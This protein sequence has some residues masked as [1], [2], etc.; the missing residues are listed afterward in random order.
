MQ[1]PAH[2]QLATDL[3]K[4]NKG[5]SR[6]WQ[7]LSC[8]GLCAGMSEQAQSLALV[9]LEE[10]LLW[11]PLDS[12]GDGLGTSLAAARLD[13]RTYLSFSLIFLRTEGKR[14]ERWHQPLTCLELLNM[15][16][17]NLSRL[18][19]GSPASQAAAHTQPQDSVEAEQLINSHADE[20]PVV[21]THQF[22]WRNALL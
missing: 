2:V 11:L 18:G 17:E 19:K 1:L 21:R 9:R 4:Q 3:H 14:K 12:D 10:Q 16:A 6:E 8:A 7:G 15:G 22:L 20:A 13:R 5:R